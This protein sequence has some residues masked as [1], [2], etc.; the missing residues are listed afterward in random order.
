MR[1]IL[2]RLWRDER[3]VTGVEYAVMVVFVALV[4]AL[5]AGVL[6]TSLSSLFSAVGGDIATPPP[7]PTIP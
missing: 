5:G 6:G 3:G 4:L 7:L 2:T 1:K